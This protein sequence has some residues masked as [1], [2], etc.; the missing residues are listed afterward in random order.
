MGAV[1]PSLSPEDDAAGLPAEAAA[2]L[3]AGIGPERLSGYDLA[4]G[5]DQLRALHLYQWNTAVSGAVFEDLSTLEVVLR[6]ACHH[7]L[8][9][10]NAT[11][12]NQHP[13]YHHPVLAPRHM[14]DVGAARARVAQGKKTET[15]GRV[16]AELMLGFWRLLHSKEYEVSLWRPCLRHAYPGAA[17]LSRT[18]VYDRLDHLNTLR[19]RVAHH[20]PVHGPTIGKVP[21]DLT[22]L[23]QELLEL[24]GWLD[25]H[26]RDWVATT[27]RVPAL[28]AAKP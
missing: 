7:Q 15:E 3:R 27:S 28:L 18:Q 24:L 6:N 17:T 11:E 23:H 22:G 4:S 16:V 1:T 20:E 21:K 13:W 10:W 26:I 8:Q 5:G 9:M 14:Q 12:G 2:A 19:N 25:P